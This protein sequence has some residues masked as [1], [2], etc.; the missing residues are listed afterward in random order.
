MSNPGV[1]KNNKAGI[2][3]LGRGIHEWQ[4]SLRVAIDA[5]IRWEFQ[6]TKEPT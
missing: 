5:A 4:P 6:R 3:V 2:R 1:V